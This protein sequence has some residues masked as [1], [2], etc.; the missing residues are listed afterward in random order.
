MPLV[1]DIFLAAKGLIVANPLEIYTRVHR[2]PRIFVQNTKRPGAR[3]LR[4][5]RGAAQPVSADLH[6]QQSGRSR[7]TTTSTVK[8]SKPDL[9]IRARDGYYWAGTK[10]ETLPSLG[11]TDVNRLHHGSHG[12]FRPRHARIG[13]V[14]VDLIAAEFGLRQLAGDHDGRPVVST[15]TACWKAAS[16]GGRIRL[17]AS[18]RRS[19]RY[20]RRHRAG[21]RGRGRELFSFGRSGF[22]RTMV[23]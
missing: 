17:S 10:V 16:S 5:R 3:R 14:S 19:H 8:Y 13:A 2:R 18:R 1:K 7:I 22:R 20:G 15:S 12:A 9:S 4:L 23:G 6:P 21:R 11:R